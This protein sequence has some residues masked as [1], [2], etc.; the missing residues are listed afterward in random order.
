MYDAIIVGA[1]PV[2]LYAARLC[3][4]AGLNI[5]ILEE[6]ESIGKPDHCSGLISTNLED[7]V[8]IDKSWVEHKVEGAV[9]YSGKNKVQLKKNDTAAYVINRSKFDKSL[10][11]GLEKEILF[12]QRV[13]NIDIKDDHVEVKTS[14]DIHKAK[15]ILGCD[16]SNSIIAKE[17]G[18]K[19]RELVKGIIAMKKERNEKKYVEMWFNKK[20]AK[21]GF[22]WKI[23][24][25]KTTE[26]GM[27][28]SDAS[29]KTLES[30]FKLGAISEKKASLI[31]I[32]PSKTYFN[33]VLLIGDAAAQVKPWSGGGVVYG[34]TCAK[35]AVNVIKEALKEN[36]FSEEFLK[37]YEDQWK[38]AI[39]KNIT[40]GL[41]FREFYKDCSE[42]DIEKFFEIASKASMSNLDMDFPL[43]NAFEI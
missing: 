14:K 23:P 15:M 34:L 30:F 16:G 25:K 36:N 39:G 1:G 18:S 4:E 22:I 41:M 3:K 6:H 20:L 27:M 13:E 37:R 7:F 35:I 33:R 42:N 17:V 32:G 38:N 10:S 2:G 31:P 11:K 28:S 29:F 12:N 8:K 43:L 26:Y 9:M 19:P 24:R 5:L 40:A 21:D